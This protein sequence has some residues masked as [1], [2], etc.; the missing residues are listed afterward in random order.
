MFTSLVKVDSRELRLHPPRELQLH[1]VGCEPC[2][3]SISRT[4]ISLA[5]MVSVPPPTMTAGLAAEDATQ[6]VVQDIVHHGDGGRVLP[7]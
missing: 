2:C 7:A 6:E 4:S 3:G 1:G 5:L